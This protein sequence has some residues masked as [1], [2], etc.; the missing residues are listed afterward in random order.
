MGGEQALT[1]LRTRIEIAGR[2]WTRT[3]ELIRSERTLF[4]LQGCLPRNDADSTLIKVAALHAL[5]GARPFPAARWAAHVESELAQRDTLEC[6]PELVDALA[7]AP[8]IRSTDQRRALVMASRFAHYFVDADRFPICD[9]WT[10]AEL[11]RLS[12]PQNE[13][14]DYVHFA[15]RHSGVVEAIGLT[16]ARKLGPY[17]WLASQ[18]RVWRRNPRTSIQH[19]ARALFESGDPDL[20]WIDPF[21]D[22]REAYAAA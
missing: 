1:G 15:T 10:E 5:D 18:Y 13:A 19:S 14:G 17:L 22:P 12:A 4:A 7:A 2:L 3:P 11:A 21:D 20:R 16:R 8:E 9:S 6:G